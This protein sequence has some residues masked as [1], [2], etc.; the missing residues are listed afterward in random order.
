MKLKAA[1]RAKKS[2]MPEK[3]EKE[4]LNAVN[5]PLNWTNKQRVL[6]MCSRGISFHGRHLMK[7][8]HKMMPHSKTESKL[9]KKESLVSINEIADMKNCQNCIYLE[10]RKKRDLYMWI[11]KIP[12][13]PSIKFSVENIH[14]M[15]ELKLAGNC[16]KG[17]RPILSFSSDF[18]KIPHLKLMKCVLTDV[19]NVPLNH[20][21]SKPF[22]DHV[23]QISQLNNR[24]WFRNYQ[25]VDQEKFDLTEI[26]PRF[27]LNP[28]KIFNGS[29]SGITLWDNPKYLSPNIRFHMLKKSL[30]EKYVRRTEA[31]K[32]ISAKKM[33]YTDETVEKFDDIYD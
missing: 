20:P 13:G 14:T 24:L 11:S 4:V 16:L 32:Q 12:N 30:S 5:R 33:S 28:I 23:I 29:F 10:M 27:V 15:E 21:R 18:D 9:E 26:G 22:V 2:S 17:S 8:F 1:K 31:K 19:F 3:L 6:L 25:I 7:N